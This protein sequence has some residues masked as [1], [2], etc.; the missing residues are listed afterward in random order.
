MVL[1]FLQHGLTLSISRA[2]IEITDCGKY[3]NAGYSITDNMLCAADA[4]FSKDSCQGDSG[5]PLFLDGDIVAGVVSF[6]VGCAQCKRC[7]DIFR[8]HLIASTLH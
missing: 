7:Q 6:G 5:G 3:K 8:V 4:L 1:L 2:D